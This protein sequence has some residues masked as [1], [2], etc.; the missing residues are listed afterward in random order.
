M[1]YLGPSPNKCLCWLRGVGGQRAP[2]ALYKRVPVSLCGKEQL[3]HFIKL[4]DV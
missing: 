4:C 3:S 1:L 2:G